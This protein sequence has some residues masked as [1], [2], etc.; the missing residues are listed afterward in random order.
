MKLVKVIYPCFILILLSCT[1]EKASFFFELEQ[2]FY[3]K[4]TPF[5]YE[6]RVYISNEKGRVVKEQV[7]KMGEKYELENLNKNE[8]YDLTF[9]T[10]VRMNGTIPYADN[11]QTFFDVKPG[12]IHITKPI[13]KEDFGF[14]EFDNE[15]VFADSSNIQE[16]RVMTGY[17]DKNKQY[18]MQY[19]FNK[20]GI[21]YWGFEKYRDLPKVV[22]AK[23]N[24]FD[25]VSNDPL[26]FEFK[27]ETN[28]YSYF[29]AAFTATISEQI[30]R[31]IHWTLHIPKSKG[32]AFS[33][34][35]IANHESA[36]LNQEA[37]GILRLE[38]TNLMNYK[39]E[40]FI[41]RMM[42]GHD[43]DDMDELP[44]FSTFDKMEMAERIYY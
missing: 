1:T 28:E 32:T 33:L 26:N 10:K 23:N 41:G 9:H 4:P 29:V 42:S 30:A 36:K 21:R 6:G 7:L 39:G 44:S 35:S 16:S 37:L 31:R 13:L 2:E 12:K 14:E 38:R 8:S 11:L 18:L 15:I 5:D 24:Y 34:P 22:P 25:I 40:D 27:P 17:S 20:K 19:S 43:R 3:S